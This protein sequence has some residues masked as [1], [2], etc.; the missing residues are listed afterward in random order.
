ME[1]IG[2][3]RI[4]ALRAMYL[5]IVVG[6]GLS[7][8]PEALSSAGVSADSDTV[9]N[10]ILIGFMVLSF[11]G[12]FFPLKMLPVLM[13]ELLWKVVWLAMFALPMHLS[14]GLDE[15]SM[16]VAFACL[17]GVV[18]TPIVLPWRYIY[19]DYFQ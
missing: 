7:N 17:I 2:K 1:T 15:Y 6:L 14:S 11:I 3:T 12:V 10:A 8:T 19:K 4:Y 5:F 13:L 18:L 16:G 9:I